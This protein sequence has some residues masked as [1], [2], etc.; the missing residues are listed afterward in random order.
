MQVIKLTL[1]SQH[2]VWITCFQKLLISLSIKCESLPILQGPGRPSCCSDLISSASLLPLSAPTT[3]PYCCSS[4]TPRHLTWGVCSSYPL[5]LDYFSSP[6]LCKPSS[7]LGSDITTLK[8]YYMKC[9]PASAFHSL[10]HPNM[11][12]VFNLR[13]YH[14]L[15]QHIFIV[16]FS[17]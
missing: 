7:I 14:L 13:V 11:F 16:C 5:W 6:D 1:C 17:Y 2:K 12:S 4:K 15:I 8:T 9:N 10:P 3:L